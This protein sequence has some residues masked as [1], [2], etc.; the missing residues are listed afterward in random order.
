MMLSVEA[1]LSK[2]EPTRRKQL[3]CAD[4]R[5]PMVLTREYFMYGDSA[6]CS[7]KCRANAYK[8]DSAQRRKD[9][10]EKRRKAETKPTSS[11]KSSEDEKTTPKAAS[12]ASSIVEPPPHVPPTL[13]L[14]SACG[15]Q[16][17]A[18]DNSIVEGQYKERHVVPEFQQAHILG[19][20]S[21]GIE[22]LGFCTVFCETQEKI[23]REYQD[24]VVA[25][26]LKW[27]MSGV[28]HTQ[29]AVSCVK[30]EKKFEALLI[31]GILPR[32]NLIL[33]GNMVRLRSLASFNTLVGMSH[34]IKIDIM[35]TKTLLGKPTTTEVGTAGIETCQ[36]CTIS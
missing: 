13:P 5:L 25:C 19:N 28:W 17:S 1:P 3:S 34:Q 6:F 21:Q 15:Q 12:R 36:M 30:S 35:W 22:K 23:A 31:D 33:I 4:C 20:G 16:F 10:V 7:N 27:F 24:S 8:K 11:G 18:V 2:S 14:E 29:L 26:K 9:R 32:A